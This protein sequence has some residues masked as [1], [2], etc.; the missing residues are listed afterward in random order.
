MTQP[1]KELAL[2][3]SK[4]TPQHRKVPKAGL[5]KILLLSSCLNPS[6]THSLT[7]HTSNN[8]YLPLN[9]PLSH[10]SGSVLG[11]SKAGHT[12]C[13]ARCFASDPGFP[14]ESPSCMPKAASATFPAPPVHQKAST[15]LVTARVEE[16]KPKTEG[17]TGLVIFSTKHIAP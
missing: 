6:L 7:P 13:S 8:E 2:I 15:R 3:I 14:D 17:S 10:V 5:L 4:T 16:A 9:P 11:A 1:W 12:L